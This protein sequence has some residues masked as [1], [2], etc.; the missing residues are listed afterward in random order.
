LKCAIF[1]LSGTRWHFDNY[2]E[3]AKSR[4]HSHQVHL[5]DIRLKNTRFR[6]A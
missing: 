4:P 5:T 3:I 6:E 2:L 1:A